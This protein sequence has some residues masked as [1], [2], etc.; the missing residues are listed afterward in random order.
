MLCAGVTYVACVAIKI[1]YLPLQMP[2]N[3]NTSEGEKS[4]QENKLSAAK[5]FAF[6]RT[7]RSPQRHA[8]ERK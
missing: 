5:R 1:N 4:K 7:E 3:S 6:F 2:H 8:G